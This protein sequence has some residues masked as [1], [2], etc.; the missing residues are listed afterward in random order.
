MISRLVQTLALI[1]AITALPGR[2][3]PAPPRDNPYDVIGKVFSPFWSVLLADTKSPNKACTM[4]IELT[5]VAGRLPK[6]MSGATL[7]AAVQFPDKVK[8]QAPVFGETF[9]VCRDGDK[10]WA[11]PG[12]KVQFLLERFKG[13]PPPTKKKNTPLFLPI[14]AQQA[15]FLPALFTVARPDVAEIQNLNGEDCRVISAG[16]MPELARAAKAEGFRAKMWVA[17]G[18]VPRRVEITQPDFVAMTDIKD[19]KFSPSL[20][21]STWE[22]PAGV[23]DIYWT[24]SDRLDAVLFVVMNSLKM[25]ESD[26]PWLQIK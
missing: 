14:T 25:K 24:D 22:P 6:Q 2:A 11:Y 20:P 15:I 17:P 19:L 13:K 3:Q 8:L 5:E 12:A 18:Y 16:L 10:V 4:T 21:A 7:Q 26:Q 23:T 9:T 1:L